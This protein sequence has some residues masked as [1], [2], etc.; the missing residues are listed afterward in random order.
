MAPECRTCALSARAAL[1]GGRRPWEHKMLAIKDVAQH[2][3]RGKGLV[4]LVHLPYIETRVTHR[5]VGG[6]SA[7]LSRAV[8]YAPCWL[9]HVSV[10]SH[11]SV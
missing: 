8:G 9:G 11:I 3:P 4:Y 5:S 10:F 6:Q 1:S 2:T 7:V